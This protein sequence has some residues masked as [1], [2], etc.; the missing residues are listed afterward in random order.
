MD[1]GWQ[2][3]VHDGSGHD[4]LAYLILLFNVSPTEYGIAGIGKK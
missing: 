1:D 4:I 2:L 3:R